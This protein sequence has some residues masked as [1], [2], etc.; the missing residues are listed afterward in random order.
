M[1]NKIFCCAYVSFNYRDKFVEIVYSNSISVAL[2]LE[3][4]LQDQ[5]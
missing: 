2:R 3:T 1:H 5:Y 4:E